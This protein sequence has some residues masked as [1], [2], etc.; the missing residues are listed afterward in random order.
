[1]PDPFT[2]VLLALSVW[3]V[4]RMVTREKGP[5]DCFEILR[6]LAGVRYAANTGQY[7]AT[8][9]WGG[10]LA[11][12]LCLSVWLAL[13]FAL[14]WYFLPFLTP[15]WFVLALTGVSSALEIYLTRKG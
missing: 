1:M 8:G 14:L 5:W 11:C 2:F 13:A 9:F 15:L 4:S 7:S 6:D 12:P 10:L 3:R